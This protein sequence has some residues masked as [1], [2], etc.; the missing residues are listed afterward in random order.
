MDISFLKNSNCLIEALRA[1]LK[2]H[3]NIIIYKKKT[4]F[5]YSFD[6]FF[7]YCGVS[8]KFY[9]FSS[10]GQ[11]LNMWQQLWFKGEVKEYFPKL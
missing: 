9:H 2:N 10:N 8:D 6:H 4:E 1:Y 5:T 7:W 11:D 3:R